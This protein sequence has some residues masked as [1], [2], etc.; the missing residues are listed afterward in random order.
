MDVIVIPPTN[1]I[2]NISEANPGSVIAP[3]KKLIKK[4]I[5]MMKL[6]AVMKTPTRPNIF[7]GLSENE[8]I[9]LDA[10][11][12]NF[13]KLYELAPSILDACSTGI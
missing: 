6:I 7:K 9:T 4:K 1:H 13:R 10:N 8:I 2:D 3:T 12:N 11:E 5:K